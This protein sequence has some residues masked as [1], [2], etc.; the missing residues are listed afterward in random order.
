MTP[1]SSTE[2]DIFFFF[3]Q[4]RPA[5]QLTLPPIVWVPRT[6]SSELWVRILTFNNNWSYTF[7]CAYLIAVRCG[8]G[9][10][11]L[12]TVYHST[13]VIT[14]ALNVRTPKIASYPSR[15]SCVP[16]IKC[17]IGVFPIGYNIYDSYTI[18]LPV[19]VTYL[20]VINN[21]RWPNPQSVI[22]LS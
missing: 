9:N 6:H 2:E 12:S 7:F 5:M 3:T 18:I 1:F 4:T 19:Y 20:C 22:L 21:I 8:S 17:G 13:L 15:F 16:H 10:W 11:T 14:H